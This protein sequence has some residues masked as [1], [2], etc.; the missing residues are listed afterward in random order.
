MSAPKDV[1]PEENKRRMQAGELYF[2]FT[3]DLKAARKRCRLALA[4]YNEKSNDM[5]RRQQ[6]ELY[7]E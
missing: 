4:L 7:Q 1:E 2:A 3:P 6:I 5:S